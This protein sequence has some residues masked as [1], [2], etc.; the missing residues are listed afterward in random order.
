M[1][2]GNDCFSQG[3]WTNALTAFNQAQEIERK[4]TFS[5][6]PTRASLQEF[7]VKS[8]V[9]NALEQGKKAFAEA[10]WDQA[11]NQYETAV[12]LLEENSEI[13]RR[14][15]PLESQQK[16]SR[17]MLHAA[18]I[19]DKQRVAN[20]LKN[21]ELSQAIDKMQAI[22]ETIAMSSFV[23][24]EEFQTIIKETRLTINQTRED[25][26]MAGHISYLT[27][28]YQKL[29]TQNN[30]ALNAERLSRPR[31]TF[32]KK[33]GNKRLYKVQCFEEGHERPVLLQASYI[34]DP[35][36]NKWHFFNKD[37]AINE[38]ETVSAGQK[39][40]SSAYQAQEDRVI[41]EQ[42]SYLTDNFQTLFIQTTPSLLPE[43]LSRPQARFLRKI[44]EKMLFML[45]CFD[46]EAGN[47][48]PL[49]AGYLYDP[50]SKQWEPY[51][52]EAK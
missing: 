13:L 16:I 43:S 49:K 25:L 47:S 4:F 19:R 38:Q 35:I 12:Q 31:I 27:D 45:Q 39:M 32:L 26:L 28:N 24:E 41:S 52:N 17:I 18:I 29:F 11:I 33:I 44:G 5:D 8:K 2:S 36:T 42:I 46:Q 50:A 40:L 23:R 20:H 14:D 37:N 21:K 3:D 34:H 10:Q 15:N 7:I 9:F 30:P 6:E 51:N 22:I 48:A 1:A